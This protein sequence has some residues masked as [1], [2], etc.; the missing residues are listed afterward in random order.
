MAVR[1]GTPDLNT[2]MVTGALVELATDRQLFR[3]R[4]GGR[5]RRVAFYL[6]LLVGALVGAVVVKWRGPGW[7]LVVVA[8]VKGLVAV[9]FLGSWGV[10]GEATVGGGKVGVG[11]GEVED[12]TERK[13]ERSG[14]WKGEAFALP[15]SRVLWGD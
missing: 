14:S 4:N 10:V 12:G 15:M 13:S 11:S 9:S 2:T 5:N 6:C 8:G 7:G 1:L 3:V